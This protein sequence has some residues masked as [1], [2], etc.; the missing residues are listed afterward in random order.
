MSKYTQDCVPNKHPG[1]L[2]YLIKNI[3]LY[4]PYYGTTLIF[5]IKSI[6]YCNERS[7]CVTFYL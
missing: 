7:F 3:T 5:A 2:I 4:G 6:W 1:I